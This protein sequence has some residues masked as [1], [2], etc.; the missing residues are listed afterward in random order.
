MLPETVPEAPKNPIISF[1]GRSFKFTWT[2]STDDGGSAITRFKVYASSESDNYNTDDQYCVLK[3]NE[4][5]PLNYCLIPIKTVI[6][7]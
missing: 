7:R 5:I 3:S 2:I 6:D 4:G 1:E